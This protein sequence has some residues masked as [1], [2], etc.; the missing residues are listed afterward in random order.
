MSNNDLL[1]GRRNATG[2]VPIEVPDG[3]DFKRRF[4]T[5]EAC[6]MENTDIPQSLSTRKKRHVRISLPPALKP[7]PTFLPP[8]SPRQDA[9]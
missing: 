1:P 4:P 8:H 3:A 6:R 7:A 5:A 2:N 9:L